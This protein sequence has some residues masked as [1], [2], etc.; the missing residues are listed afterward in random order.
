MQHRGIKVLVDRVCNVKIDHDEVIKI[1]KSQ[2]A[3]HI[4]EV[5]YLHL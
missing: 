2:L 5:V 3:L 4:L 1:S